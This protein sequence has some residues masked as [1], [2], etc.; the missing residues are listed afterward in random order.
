MPKE[1][2]QQPRW[3]DV[4]NAMQC[5]RI[6]ISYQVYVTSCIAFLIFFILTFAIQNLAHKFTI[7]PREC[8]PAQLPRWADVHNALQI[9]QHYIDVEFASVTFCN[10]LCTLHFKLQIVLFQTL[11]HNQALW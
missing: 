11:P 8:A 3:A 9:L 10:A 1:C 2:A 4:H 5:I 6:C 7:V